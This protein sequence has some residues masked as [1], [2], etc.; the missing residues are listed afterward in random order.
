MIP[1]SKLITSS[2]RRLATQASP[3]PSSDRV[4]SYSE[5]RLLGFSSEKMFSVVNNVAEYPKFVPWCRQ[6]DVKQISKNVQVAE[7]QIGF[8]P[9]SEHYTSRVTS[10]EPSVVRSVCTDGRVF[11]VLETTWRFGP[12]KPGDPNTTMLHFS[13]DFEFK[14]ALHAYFAHMFFDQVVKTMVGAFLK[15]TE[16]IYGA[17][18]FDHFV[19][20]AEVLAYKH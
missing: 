20:K 11:N 5:R 7:L 4:M 14:S 12:G 13:L 1:R 18:S 8:P 16:A 17:P 15:R 9:I 3:S 10:L 6:A 19:S 2:F